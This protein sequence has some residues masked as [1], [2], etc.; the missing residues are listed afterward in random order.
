[1]CKLLM[2][3]H[4]NEAYFSLFSTFFKV[5]HLSGRA[6]YNTSHKLTNQELDDE[7]CFLSYV[8][9][10]SYITSVFFDNE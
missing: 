1:M 6:T 10:G 5:T 3:R 2:P 4:G 8:T 9:K 7:I